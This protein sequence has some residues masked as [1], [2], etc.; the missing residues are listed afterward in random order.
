[1]P[2]LL[3]WTA[4]HTDGMSLTRELCAF[5]SQPFATSV[6]DYSFLACVASRS[7][8]ADSPCSSVWLA[9][10]RGYPRIT[11]IL[12]C[13]S[14]RERLWD[15]SGGLVELFHV[16]DPKYPSGTTRPFPEGVRVGRRKLQASSG[17]LFSPL[18]LRWLFFCLGPNL[19]PVI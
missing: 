7:H 18:L 9:I 6:C 2:H 8:R 16:W 19:V 15:L 10:L 1:M 17:K 12:S 5:H 11:S 14:K 3:L 13:F 4:T